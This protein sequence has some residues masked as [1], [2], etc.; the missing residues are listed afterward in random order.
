MGQ[1][2]RRLAV[3]LS[4]TGR[5]L[6]NLL[7]RIDA[8][9]LRAQV[10]LVI[11][12]RP[13]RGAQIAR[14]RGVDTKIIPGD[15]PPEELSRLASGADAGWIALAGYL[16]LVR[17]PDDYAGR[18]VNIHPALLPSFG[19]RNM[20]GEHVHRAVLEAGCKVSGCTVHICDRRYDAGPIVLQRACLVL[21]DDT[22]D[23][24]AARVFELEL[25]AYPEALELLMAGRVKVE[26][27]RTRITEQ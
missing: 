1:R 23:S 20:Y 8:G 4:G 5:T 3:M 12:S 11:A 9:S 24:L 18:I 2:S 26:G 21:D 25:D 10:T 19:G 13:C 16:R 14:S 27:R 17:I 7:D 15:I 22:S 6:E